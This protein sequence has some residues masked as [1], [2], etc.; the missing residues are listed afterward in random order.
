MIDLKK[1]TP[2]I[3]ARLSQAEAKSEGAKKLRLQV[4]KVEKWLREQGIKRKPLIFKEVA[5]GTDPTRPEWKAAIA[6]ALGKKKSVV[7]V[8]DY[9]RWSRDMREGMAAS[10]PLYHADI[11]IVSTLDGAA[12]MTGTNANPRPDGDMMWGI[13]TTL[14]GREVATTKE[15]ER[16]TGKTLR[17]AGIATVR[18]LA[19]YP[20]AAANPWA[21][22]S[23]QYPRLKAKDINPSEY[24]NLIADLTAIK[25]R[26][27]SPGWQW[28]RN[29]L[30]RWL[31]IKE[32]L[33]PEA[34]AEW[35]G[36]LNRVRNY[37][38]SEGHDGAGSRVEKGPISWPVK[39]LRRM[40]NAYL[41]EPDKYP[42][43]TDDEWVEW[44]SNFEPY[45]SVKDS[46]TYLAVS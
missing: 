43:P 13:K 4:K 26:K 33:S 31:G 22:L 19:L 23:D 15:K 44:T 12:M 36:F 45:L 27:V 32:S 10:I 20:F 8:L 40:S 7:V 18:G 30:P 2:I 9:S 28:Q 39:A 35:W 17:E 21:I 29:T 38:K 42:K 46:K 16:V 34:Y 11:P 3:Y 5:S 24:G 37:E 14:V 6:S 1:R 25:G 41:N